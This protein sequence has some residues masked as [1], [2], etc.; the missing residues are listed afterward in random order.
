MRFLIF[1]D[2]HLTRSKDCNKKKLDVGIQVINTTEADYYVCCGDVTDSG[3]IEDYMFAREKIKGI[4]KDVFYVPGNRDSQNVGD[5]LWNEYFGERYFVETDDKQKVKILGLDSSQPDESPGQIGK[6]GIRMIESTFSS[7][8]DDWTKV[9]VFHHHTLPIH[10][11]G[12]LRGHLYDAGDI[13]KLIQDLHIDIVL[14]GHKHVSNVYRLSNGKSHSLII[15]TASLSSIKNRYK[16]KNS[17]TLLEFD[18]KRLKASVSIKE[19]DDLEASWIPIFKKRLVIPTPVETTPAHYIRIVHI[20][21]SE[22]ADNFTIEQFVKAI[23][24]IEQ[25]EPDVIVHCGDITKNSMV[26]EFE[27]ARK[28]LANLSAQKV[29]LPGPRDYFPLGLEVFEEFIGPFETTIQNEKFRI[30]GFDTCT[31]AEKTG[32]LGRF[33]TRR[34][35]KN[36]LGSSKLNIVAMHHNLIP[37]SRSRYTSELR[38]AGDVLYN[39]VHNEVDLILTGSKNYTGVWQVENTVI[40]NSGT[41]SSATVNSKKGN[42]YCLID[43]FKSFNSYVYKIKEIEVNTGNEQLLGMYVIPFVQ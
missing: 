21:N 42:T 15:N 36:S 9:L 13:I 27:I 28:L 6:E 5:L 14:H 8:D 16:G 23:N 34:I 31:L 30:M 26:K 43:I 33:R 40:V 24:L 12:R 10:N 32:S 22:F 38:D 25:Q 17:L 20:S 37:L 2:T 39:L 41:V 11:M 1:S 29:V 35:I 19:L 3:S 7:L 18:K 4:N